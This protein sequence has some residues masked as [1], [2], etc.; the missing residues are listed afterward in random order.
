[1]STDCAIDQMPKG[2][3]FLECVLQN[4]FNTAILDRFS[5]LGLDDWWLTAGC[6][7]QSVW[8][9][10]AGK[11][12]DAGIADYDVFYFDPDITW[13]SEDRVIRQGLELYS[14]L[15]VNIEIRNQARVPIWYPKKYGFD[16]GPVLRASDGI[17]RFAYQT[18]AIGLRKEDNGTYRIY[19][20]FGLDLVMQG[21]VIP[22][23][24]LP[25]RDVY[26]AKV[27]RWQKIW[28]DLKIMPWHDADKDQDHDQSQS[29]G[30]TAARP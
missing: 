22:N 30:R 14:E 12:P 9:M 21:H 26:E 29:S 20:P 13:R 24:V 2:P 11:A 27:A 17:D 15:S 10:K 7:A 25:I 3:E 1:M 5:Q 28:P 23:D 19:A 6:L 16:Y 8:N 18:T 4:R